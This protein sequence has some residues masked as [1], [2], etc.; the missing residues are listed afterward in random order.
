MLTFRKLI[1][2]FAKKIIRDEFLELIHEIYVKVKVK[3]YYVWLIIATTSKKIVAYHFS[4]NRSV[5]LAITVLLDMIS[6][7]T[8]I[9][10][11]NPSNAKIIVKIHFK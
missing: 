4:N 11:K 10:H 8:G 2:G 3:W 7:S 5:K 1:T 9:L 6:G